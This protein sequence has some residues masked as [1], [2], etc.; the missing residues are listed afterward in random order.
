M[1]LHFYFLTFKKISGIRNFYFGIGKLK[2]L[3]WI[4]KIALYVICETW[5]TPC[6]DCWHNLSFFFLIRLCFPF[7]WCGIFPHLWIHYQVFKVITKVVVIV[8]HMTKIFMCKINIKRD[9][10]MKQVHFSCSFSIPHFFTAF[11][12]AESGSTLKC[13][14]TEFW[15]EKWIM[16]RNKYFM[17]FF[18]RMK[19]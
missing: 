14:L 7:I 4:G 9:C 19:W 16:K 10:N 8:F 5:L 11:T 6:R 2:W 12:P 15:G 3:K 17:Y 13:I 1:F 18:F